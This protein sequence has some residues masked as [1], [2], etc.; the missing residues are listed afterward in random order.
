MQLFAANHWTVHRDPNGEVRERTQGAEG[1]CN[2][3]GRITISTKQNPQSSQ[4]LNHQ[5]KSTHERTHGYSCICSKEWPYMASIGREA[6]CPLKDMCPSV[7]ECQGGEMG[8]SGWVGEHLH[9]SRVR[10]D[11]MEVWEGETAKR[12]NT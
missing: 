12:D 5:P 9:R 3:I 6:H 1:V 11:G 10:G 7:A 8:E 2:P 4:G